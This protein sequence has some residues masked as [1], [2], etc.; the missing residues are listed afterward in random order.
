MTFVMK[1]EGAL[2]SDLLFIG[3][4]NMY[5]VEEIDKSFVIASVT[6]AQSLRLEPPSLECSILNS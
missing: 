2:G 4:I 5:I 6:P 3:I 1:Q